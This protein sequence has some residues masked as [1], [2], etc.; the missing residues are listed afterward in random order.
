[1]G[2]PNLLANVAHG[3]LG[4]VD[5]VKEP[6]SAR[7]CCWD[8]RVPTFCISMN[9]VAEVVLFQEPGVI[10][11]PGYSYIRLSGPFFLM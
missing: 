10:L 1:M 7:T 9:K 4:E 3:L 11:F 8:D 5:E 6:S 2:A